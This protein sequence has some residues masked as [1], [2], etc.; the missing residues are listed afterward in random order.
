MF[1]LL[2]KDL[3]SDFYSGRWQSRQ[4]GSA[5]AELYILRKIGRAKVRNGFHV[6]SLVVRPSGSAGAEF[7]IFSSPVKLEV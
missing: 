2:L 6:T 3:I 7:Q 4:D 1:S 5:E